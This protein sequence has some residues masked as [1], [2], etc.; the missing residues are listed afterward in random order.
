MGY[1]VEA[2][3][4][5]LSSSGVIGAVFAMMIRKAMKN[6]ADDAERRRK[7]YIE[8]E[9][10]RFERDR[11]ASELLIALVRYSRKLCSE[12]ELE[13][14]ESNYVSASAKNDMTLKRHYIES[15]A[16]ERR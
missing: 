16:R 15:K 7:E 5:V 12:S 8:A 13:I 2:I 11:A 6:A 9:T 10:V 3:A 14:A 4:V 1:L